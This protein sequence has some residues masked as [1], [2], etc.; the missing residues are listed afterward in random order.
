[1]PPL[2]HATQTERDTH[3]LIGNGEGIHWPELD[4]TFSLTIE[5][6]LLDSNE[7]KVKRAAELRREYAQN[8][9]RYAFR[10]VE[11]I[12]TIAVIHGARDDVT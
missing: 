12:I 10:T 7:N 1:V 5:R 3:R 6:G 9:E 8:S 2:L 4:Q 11:R